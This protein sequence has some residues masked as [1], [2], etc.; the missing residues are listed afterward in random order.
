MSLMINDT[1]ATYYSGNHY[2]LFFYRK[3]VN[4]Y[5]CRADNPNTLF[6]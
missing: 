1:K 5:I 4:D 6:K 3:Y 2:L